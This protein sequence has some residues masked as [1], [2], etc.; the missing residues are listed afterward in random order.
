[1]TLGQVLYRLD[2]QNKVITRVMQT[3]ELFVLEM[4]D[5]NLEKMAI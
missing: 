5:L 1:M 4:E 2:T 3:E